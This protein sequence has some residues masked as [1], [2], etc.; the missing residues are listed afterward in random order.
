MTE[1]KPCPRC[2]C[3]PRFK[4]FGDVIDIWCCP[5]LSIRKSEVIT[6]EERD[7]W[8]I[9]TAS[10]ANKVEVKALGEAIKMW[11]AG[12]IRSINSPYNPL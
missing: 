3:A 4:S 10:Y 1:L 11:N 5:C 9:R 2:G 6:P 8:D 7:T 12:L